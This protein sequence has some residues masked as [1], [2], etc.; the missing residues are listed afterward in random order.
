VI[1]W[2]L[3]GENCDS[4]GFKHREAFCDLKKDKCD[5]MGFETEK[6]VSSWNLNREILISCD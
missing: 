2:D 4:M 3:N 6:H 1:S 5:S